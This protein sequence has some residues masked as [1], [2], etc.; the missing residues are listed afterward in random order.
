MAGNIDHT[1]HFVQPGQFPGYPFGY[2]GNIFW[3]GLFLAFLGVDMTLG[4]HIAETKHAKFK[5]F[6]TPNLL[7]LDNRQKS[8]KI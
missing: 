7:V 3:M 4:Q 6:C 8:A 1:S 5:P 2:P